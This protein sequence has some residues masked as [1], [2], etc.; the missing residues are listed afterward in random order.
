MD[1]CLWTLDTQNRHG[2]IKLGVLHLLLRLD[3]SGELR[4]VHEVDQTEM[5]SGIKEHHTPDLRW[6]FYG[7]YVF[8][9]CYT[10]EIC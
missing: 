6:T 9:K 4:M 7:A 2:V 8:W 10:P 3:T 1:F 5:R